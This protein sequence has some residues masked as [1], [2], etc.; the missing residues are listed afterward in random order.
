M[1]LVSASAPKAL[2]FAR[3]SW[4]PEP[5]TAIGS[6]AEVRRAARARFAAPAA[7]LASE[8]K[9]WTTA[10]PSEDGAFG[11]TSPTESRRR[12]EVATDD[13]PWLLLA[14][15][16]GGAAAGEAASRPL[17]SSG[18]ESSETPGGPRPPAASRAPRPRDA[19]D[20]GVVGVFATTAFFVAAE[21]A[22]FAARR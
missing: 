20:A 10:E 1:A 7:G 19:D 16:N 14:F 21:E 6:C 18:A 3:L 8:P 15:D 17:G 13:R 4:S 5:S 9:S 12:R 22:A 2:R 11:S